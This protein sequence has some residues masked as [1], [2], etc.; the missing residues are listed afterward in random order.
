MRGRVSAEE[1]WMSEDRDMT[2]RGLRLG[3]L[4]VSTLTLLSG[5]G[6]F[7]GGPPPPNQPQPVS[8]AKL[9]TPSKPSQ[10]LPVL[11][12]PLRMPPIL[13]RNPAVDAV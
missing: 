6:W 4:G 2:S 8:S 9:D 11:S 5:C 10:L 7:D 12:C 1:V 3:L 13:A